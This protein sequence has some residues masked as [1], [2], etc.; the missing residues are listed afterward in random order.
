MDPGED[1]LKDKDKAEK[2]LLIG[3]EVEK[4]LIATI[5]LNYDMDKEFLPQFKEN[6]NEATNMLDMTE[7]FI[8]TACKA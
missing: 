5:Y 7:S 4:A 2:I 3:G 8:K 6:L 1:V